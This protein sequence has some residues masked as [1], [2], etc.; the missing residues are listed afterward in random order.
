MLAQ[1]SSKKAG[2]AFSNS[3]SNSS[4]PIASHFSDY[5]LKITELNFN[6]SAQEYVSCMYQ[7]RLVVV[8]SR[9]VQT[10]KDKTSLL[11]QSEYKLLSFKKVNNSWVQPYLL[12]G[13]FTGKENHAGLTFSADETRVYYT[14]SSRHNPDVYQLFTAEKSNKH[15][16]VWVNSK[17]IAI[18]STIYSIENPHLTSDGNT[19]YFSSDMP[20]GYGGYDLYKAQ[21]LKTGKLGNIVNL[22]PKINTS[23]DENFPSITENKSQLFFASNTRGGFGGF[24]LYQAF[25]QGADY[26]K[27]LNL[28]EGINTK[29][30]EFALF[31]QDGTNGYFSSN[32]NSLS[33]KM[34]I[35]SFAKQ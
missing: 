3:N 18:T 32:K 35:Y 28:G 8:S 5:S 12:A 16:S 11:D 25:M 1:S 13:V 15:S 17:A 14:K 9:K 4:K 21:V 2:L 7:N 6:T 30:D 29:Y 26:S 10:A 31:T 19:L 34:N 22:G 27:P 24:D 23:S 33:K 20:G